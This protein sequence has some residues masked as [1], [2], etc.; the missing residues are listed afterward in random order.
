MLVAMIA[1]KEV[2]ET[3]ETCYCDRSGDVEDR[4]PVWGEDKSEALQC[5]QCGHLDYLPQLDAHARRLVF[6]EAER[7]YLARL[8]SLVQQGH[9]YKKI[10]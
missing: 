4:N 5:P 3:Q 9:G 7:R 2:S 1:W 10:A 6:G 8:E